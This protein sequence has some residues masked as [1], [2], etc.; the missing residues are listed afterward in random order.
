MAAAL[1]LT[2]HG[3]SDYTPI[4]QE[5]NRDFTR[6]S[7]PATPRR[8]LYFAW[9]TSL[10]GGTHAVDRPFPARGH[11]VASHARRDTGATAR[12]PRAIDMARRDGVTESFGAVLQTYRV[13]ARLS[14]LALSKICGIHASIINRFERGDRTPADAE[15]IDRLAAG[16]AVSAAERDRLRAAGGFFPVAIERL[17]AADA[18]LLLVAD[19]LADETIPPAER[20]EFRALIRI[21]A[22]R[23]RSVPR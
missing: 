9:L 15:T 14:Q 5:S 20:D 8:L 12:W 6:P 11:A 19:I 16:L 22:R 18:D 3:H 7:P 1:P 10:N 13:R 17:G 23:W 2:P 21:G 4:P